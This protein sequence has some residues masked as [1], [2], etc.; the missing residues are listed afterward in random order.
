MAGQAGEWKAYKNTE[1][2]FRVLFPVDPTDTVN[3][4]SEGIQ[5]HT[6]LA[7]QKPVGFTVVY[8][9]MKDE[10]P[11]DAATYEIYKNGVFKELPN[12]NVAKDE[13]AAPVVQ[14]YIGHYYRLNCGTV[15]MTGNLYWGKRFAYAV[16]AVYAS[17]VAEPA[18]TKKFLD[19]FAVLG[20]S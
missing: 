8:A 16:L 10:Q 15:N 9:S 7:L 6:L 17:N 3:P 5:S 13:P 4:S 20:P 1:G 11:V 2:N 14:G 18:D 12:C 19:S